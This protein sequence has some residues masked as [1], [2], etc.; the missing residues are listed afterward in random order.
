MKG[1]ATVA[2]E[3]PWLAGSALFLK[4]GFEVVDTAPPTTSYW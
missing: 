2:R 4:N 3:R 1:V